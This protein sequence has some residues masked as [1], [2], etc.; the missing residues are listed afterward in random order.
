MRD[1]VATYVSELK[2]K[3]FS[4]LSKLD[5]YQGKKIKSGGK[6]YVLSIWKETIE[7][8]EIKVVVQ[9]YRYWFLGVGKM[10]AE[11][12]IVNVDGEITNLSRENLYDFS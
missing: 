8:R 4:E 11:G 12:F 5:D 10:Y 3:S 1:L 2:G 6:T 9:V 7:K